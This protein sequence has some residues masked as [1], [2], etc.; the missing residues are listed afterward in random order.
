MNII[1][2]QFESTTVRVINKE[3]EPWFVAKD[4]AL[5]LGYPK[6][7]TVTRFLDEDELGAH[8]VCTSAGSRELS[9]INES[10][11]YSAILKSRRYEAKKFKKWVTRDVLPCIR[12]TGSYGVTQIDW[13]NPTQIAGFLAQSLQRVQEQDEEI[14]MLTPKAKFHDQVIQS[15]DSLTIAE[16]AKIL[17]TGRNRLMQF[18]RHHGWINR[19]NEPYQAKIESGDMDLKLSQFDHPRQGV[20]DR[21]TPLITGRGLVKLKRMRADFH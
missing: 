18:L 12:K 2:F 6:A 16:A 7:N 11:L 21:I 3:G 13:N 17:D 9:I 8:N 5:A 15:E 19:F 10:G 20:K 1:P 4:V 14:A